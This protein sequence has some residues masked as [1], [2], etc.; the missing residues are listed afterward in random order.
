MNLGEPDTGGLQ[1]IRIGYQLGILFRQI[2][3][4][5]FQTTY[6]SFIGQGQLVHGRQSGDI[7]HQLGGGVFPAELLDFGVGRLQYI[8]V[9]HQG[10]VRHLAVEGIQVFHGFSVFQGQLIRCRQGI[11]GRHQLVKPFFR[12][13]LGDLHHGGQLVQVGDLGFFVVTEVVIPLSDPAELKIVV[14]FVF[15]DFGHPVD[16]LFHVIAGDGGVLLIADADHIVAVPV[17]GQV[18]EL[19]DGEGLGDVLA[20]RGLHNPQLNEI[21]F[22]AD[23]VIQPFIVLEHIDVHLIEHILVVLYM[24]GILISHGVKVYRLLVF[25]G[26]VGGGQDNGALGVQL[27][28]FVNDLQGVGVHDPERRAAS[29]VSAAADDVQPVVVDDHRRFNGLTGSGIQERDDILLVEAAVGV[30]LNSQDA[31][32]GTGGGDIQP[33]VFLIIIGGGG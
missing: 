20:L 10:L 26:G 30:H 4:P 5:V 8:P 25:F 21:H 2:F 1:K 18:A 14:V 29:A 19:V 24:L 27:L 28:I 33:L 32:V 17:H 7:R 22:F 23:G 15:V 16:L 12:Q 6:G 3:Q 31:A 13:L 11:D 9:F